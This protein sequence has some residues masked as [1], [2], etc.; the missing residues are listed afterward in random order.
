MNEITLQELEAN[1]KSAKEAIELGSALE[2]LYSNR[3]FKK[4]VLTGYFEKE[5]VRLV[6]LKA[7]AES[8]DLAVQKSIVD[9]IDAIGT[10]SNYLKDITLMSG[11]AGK[12]ASADE[13]TR[14]DILFEG[15]NNG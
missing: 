2:R 6:H 14:N 4:I 8:I 7:A 11:L 12:T 15:L 3:D 5:A 10:F 1:I 13:Q 9:K